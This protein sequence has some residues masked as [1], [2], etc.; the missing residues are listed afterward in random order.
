MISGL[1][2]SCRFSLISAIFCCSSRS[3]IF[4]GHGQEKGSFEEGWR[5]ISLCNRHG[6]EG[7]HTKSRH[8]SALHAVLIQPLSV[9]LPPRQPNSVRFDFV[10]VRRIYFAILVTSTTSR[11]KNPPV[12]ANSANILRL[13]MLALYSVPVRDVNQIAVSNDNHLSKRLRRSVSRNA[14]HRGTSGYHAK[15]CPRLGLRSRCTAA[16]ATPPK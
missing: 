5:S 12:Q 4:S 16:T 3:A 1:S 10:R 8:L 13:P 7:V 6:R 14:S 2:T 9:T 15:I 11:Q